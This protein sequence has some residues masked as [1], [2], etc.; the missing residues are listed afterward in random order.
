[1]LRAAK[2]A[3]NLLPDAGHSVVEFLSGQLNSDG[4]GQDRSGNSDLYYTVF[5]LDG[6]AAMGAGLPVEATGGYLRRLGDG[7]DLDFVH[8]A[9]LARCWAAM[10]AGSLDADTAGRILQHIEAHRSADGGYGPT[11]GS[12]S[13]TVY[14]C[15]LALGAYQDL[16]GELPESEALGRCV[17]ELRSGD[18]AF[19]NQRGLKLGTTPTTAAAAVLLQQLNLPVPQAVGRWL[20]A[21]CDERGGFRATPNAPVPDLLSTATALHAL[22]GLD[23]SVA[24]IREVC[25]DFVESLWTG[26]AFR[27]HWADDVEDCEYTYYALLALGHVGS[28]PH[29]ANPM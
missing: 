27:G 6:L 11:P 1:M 7:A 24:G 19:A 13:G 25:L 14:H 5:A 3:R 2:S 23:V 8:R 26:R 29:E 16:G 21:R 4:G 9:C 12:D 15:F 22:A 10:P 28:Q 18:G 17:S 20:L